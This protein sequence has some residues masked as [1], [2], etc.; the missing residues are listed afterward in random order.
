MGGVIWSH[1]LEVSH[2]RSNPLSYTCHHS[3]FSNAYSILIDKGGYNGQV[4][5]SFIVAEPCRQYMFLR[6]NS[7]KVTKELTRPCLDG[8]IFLKI[9]YNY[10]HYNQIRGKSPIWISS[11]SFL[12]K[13]TPFKI[14]RKLR[15]SLKHHIYTS[16]NKCS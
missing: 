7:I 1:T 4:G 10:Y 6:A 8:I 14:F 9:S 12:C 5:I 13:S 2:K 15:F 3:P 11:I 16:I